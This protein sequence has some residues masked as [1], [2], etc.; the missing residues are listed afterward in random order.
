M[1]R[2]IPRLLSPDLLYVLSAMGHGDEVAIVDANYPAESSGPR[3]IR[4]DGV[5]A[6]EVLR[7]ILTVMPLDEFVPDPALCMEVVGDAASIPEAV[8]SFQKTIDEVAGN[9]V[10]IRSLE[11]FAFY[12]RAKGAFAVV[13]TGESRLYGNII[14]KKGV[15]G[16]DGD[17]G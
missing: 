12:D 6:T 8:V 2:N 5:S 11:R 14:L 16:P 9:S 10:R 3:C 7:A 15:I 1:L 17:R 4:M 13:Q